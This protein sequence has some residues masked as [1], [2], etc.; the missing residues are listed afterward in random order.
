V[1]FARIQFAVQGGHSL[2]GWK[3]VRALARTLVT[4]RPWI[5]MHQPRRACLMLDV[6]T[7]PGTAK[8]SCS[9]K[10]IEK[11]LDKRVLM[12]AD[13]VG[14]LS[15]EPRCGAVTVGLGIAV[16]RPFRL[17]PPYEPDRGCDSTSGSSNWTCRFPASSS[18]PRRHALAHEAP[19]FKLSRRTSPKYPY[20]CES[21][22]VPPRRR[23]T[24]CWMRSHR[25]NRG[26]V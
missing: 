17:A 7:G 25:G 15:A 24:L 19:Y 20:K 12:E 22:S 3:F 11:R 1:R 13:L 23:L 6:C 18:R 14:A 8:S 21:G 4:P 5:R 16:G 9:S 2:H 10:P 26:A